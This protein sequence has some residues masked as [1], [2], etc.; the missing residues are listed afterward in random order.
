MSNKAVIFDLDG[1]LYDK[2]LLPLR[3]VFSQLFKG[4]LSYLKRE[5]EVRKSISGKFFG[6][7]E[8]FEE[9]FFQ[10][11]NKKDARE[12]FYCD[13]MPEMVS[14]LSKHYKFNPKVVN[15][16]REYRI[17]GYKT[18]VFS[19]YGFV[20]EKLKAINFDLEWVDYIFEAPAL[21]GLKPCKEAF[22]SIC[23]K[24]KV[25]PEECIMFGDRED[26]DGAGAKS[27]GM[28]FIKV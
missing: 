5:R 9:H 13:Y 24:I 4:K 16:L 2:K 26:T 23:N 19:D 3:L 18:V 17:K 14:I 20:E 27:V 7:H 11:F 6:N 22:I 8:N 21:G 1:T 25:N 10:L 12:W 28:K 15:I